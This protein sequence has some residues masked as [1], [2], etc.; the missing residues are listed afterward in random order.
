MFVE[1]LNRIGNRIEGA[2]ALL[3]AAEDGIAVESVSKSPNL[4][5]ELL[6]AEMVAQVRAISDAQE[7]LA[8]G[9]LR[10]LTVRTDDLTLMASR[11][12]KNHYLILVLDGTGNLGQAR[13]ELKRATL[14]LEEDLD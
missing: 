3:I 12:G 14:L 1:R 11:V 13:F 4:D 6:V 10:Q 7:E 9:G 2:L 5:L 8:V